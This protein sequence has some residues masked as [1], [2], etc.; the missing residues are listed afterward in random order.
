MRPINPSLNGR[1]ICNTIYKGPEDLLSSS[2]VGC[3][4][5]P[6]HSSDGEITTFWKPTEEELMALRCGQVIMVTAIG[7]QPPIMLDVTRE[8]DVE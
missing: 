7:L 3:G 1:Q 6:A 5:L 4:D 8:I 2:G